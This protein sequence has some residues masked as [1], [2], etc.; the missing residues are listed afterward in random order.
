[1]AGGS[2]PGWLLSSVESMRLHE[3]RRH[4]GIAPGRLNALLG[5]VMLRTPP[6]A[7]EPDAPPAA[8]LRS[9]P[10]PPWQ[11]LDPGASGARALAAVGLAAGLAAAGYLWWSHAEPV[12]V[13]APS[14][15]RGA[16][17]SVSVVSPS[18]SG[19]VVDVTGRVRRPGLVTLPAGSRVADAV[20]AAGGPAPG[21]DSG[22]NLARRLVDGEQ[23]PV[24]VPGAVASADASVPG[25]PLDLN[26]ATSDQFDRL[27]GVG[28]TMAQ[29]IVDYR[30]QHGGFRSV[31]QLKQVS[32]I[33]ERRL[34][35]LRPLVRV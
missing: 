29:R 9:A 33:G 17:E 26:T 23:I 11:R 16:Q 34:A 18:P 22:L 13:A 7:E 30:T 15:A 35:D 6:S 20:Q 21:A 8:A 5:P 4:G 3:D 32:G 12:P 10:E 1:M 31:D 2:G 27:P 25:T 28:P 19:L 14:T 24:G